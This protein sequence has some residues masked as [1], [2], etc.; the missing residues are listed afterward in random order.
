MLSSLCP[1]RGAFS[2]V[3]RV[4]EKKGKAEFAAKFTSARG[5]RKALAL[6]EMELLSE[7]DN[8]RI[9][10]FHDAFEKKDVVVL[11]TELY[12]LGAAVNTRN[13]P[14]S[15]SKQHFLHGQIR[16]CLYIKQPLPLLQL[17]FKFNLLLC[18]KVHLN[19]S[20][21]HYRSTAL[22]LMSAAVPWRHE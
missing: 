10:Y 21:G 22:I 14:E 19:V 3:K 2:Y 5:K 16:L 12:P 6:R 1:Y 18:S 13:H 8:Q 7:L 11:I 17:C 20:Q 15:Q 9:L 4:K